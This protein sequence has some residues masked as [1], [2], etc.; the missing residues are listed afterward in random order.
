MASSPRIAFIVGGVQKGGTTALARYLAA[1]PGVDLPAGKEAHVF[2][3][4]GYL[5]A[6]TA[7]EV[8]ARFAGQWDA[9]AGDRLRGDATPITIAHERLVLRVARYNPAMRWIVLLRDPVQRAVSHYH[10]VRGWGGEPRSL[11]W[12]VLSEPWRLRRDADALAHGSP[13]RYWS[14]V[15]RGRYARQLDLLFRHFP[16]EQV[17]LLRSRDLAEHP[18]QSMGRVL[19]FLGLPP[20]PQPPSFAP[21]FE[22]RYRPLPWWSPGGWLLRLRLAGEKA[23]LR[24]RHG[25]DLDLR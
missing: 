5:D 2:D 4:P 18:A 17:L 20:F 10:M 14:Y 7:A 3:D 13:A 21:V 1:H 23:A 9:P 19:G 12:A 24:R 16:R 25:I 8:D 6:W 22:G 15:S 11:F